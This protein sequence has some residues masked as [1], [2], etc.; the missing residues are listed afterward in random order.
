MA[1][2]ASW[3]ARSS[4]LGVGV[5]L[6]LGPAAA[7]FLQGHPEAWELRVS[8]DLADSSSPRRGSNARVCLYLEKQT[9]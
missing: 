8:P 4:A 9:L 3:T 1:F 2:E 5:S 7:A 6:N